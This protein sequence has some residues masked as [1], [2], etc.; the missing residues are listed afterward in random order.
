VKQN[1]GKYV[2]PKYICKKHFKMITTTKRNK[3][4]NLIS[5]TN[6]EKLFN[7][8]WEKAEA[9]LAQYNKE[10]NDAEKRIDKGEFHS[11]ESVDVLLKKWEKS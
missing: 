4:I 5:T 3:L 8:L 1:L 6:N 7:S 9:F 11:Q 2:Q 10:I